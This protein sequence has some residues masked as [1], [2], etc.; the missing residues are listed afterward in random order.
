MVRTRVGYTGGRKKDPTYRSLGNHTEALQIDFDPAVITYED[1]LESFFTQ[2]RPV[3]RAWSQQYKSA[4]YYADEAQHDAARAVI[5]R[6]EKRTGQTI[7]TE[8]HPLETF[9]RAED[10]HQKYRLRGSAEWMNAFRRVY[11]E[12]ERKFVDS[13]EAMLVNAYLSGA[14]KRDVLA[15]ALRR[16]P[17]LL[18]VLERS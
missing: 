1:L 10:Y 13:T 15:Q 2:H 17:D 7:H 6:V 8:L 11:G 12:D 5:A 3:T 4:I 14:L 16:Q 18:S 9:Y